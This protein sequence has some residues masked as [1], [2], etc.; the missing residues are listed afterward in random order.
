MEAYTENLAKKFAEAKEKPKKF[1]AEKK[2]LQNRPRIV[3]L[4][5]SSFKPGGMFAT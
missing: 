4:T 5:L 3:G 2:E 1:K